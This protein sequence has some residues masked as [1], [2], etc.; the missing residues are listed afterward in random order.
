[1]IGSYADNLKIIDANEFDFILRLKFPFSD[2]LKVIPANDEP[3][4]IRIQNEK[5]LGQRKD[6]NIQMILDELKSL[7]DSNAYLCKKKVLTWIEKML[8]SYL[9]RLPTGTKSNEYILQIDNELFT[10]LN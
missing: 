2:A 5:L 10:V 3:G 4:W 6:P 9:Q 1:M 8:M 7:H